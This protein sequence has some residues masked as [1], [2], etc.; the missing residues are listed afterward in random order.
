MFVIGYISLRVYS[1]YM[2]QDPEV[3]RIAEENGRTVAQTLLRWG[4]QRGT[5]VIPMSDKAAHIRVW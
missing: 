5:S 4:L 2:M 3:M 1:Q